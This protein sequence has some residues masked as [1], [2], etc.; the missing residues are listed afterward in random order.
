MT[1]EKVLVVELWPFPDG[2]IPSRVAIP[3]RYPPPVDE[4][5]ATAAPSSSPKSTHANDVIDDSVNNEV[6][7]CQNEDKEGNLHCLEEGHKKSTQSNNILDSYMVLHGGLVATGGLPYYNGELM[8]INQEKNEES[9]K[10]MIIST[11]PKYY[12]W[13]EAIEACDQMLTCLSFTYLHPTPLLGNVT[14]RD[15]KV[16]VEFKRE[17]SP[18]RIKGSMDNVGGTYGMVSSSNGIPRWTAVKPYPIK[19]LLAEWIR[20]NED[21]VP[22]NGNVDTVNGNASFLFTANYREC[23][24]WALD[25]HCD[26]LTAFMHEHCSFFCRV[27]EW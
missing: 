23:E 22:E 12:T 4:I 11:I 21:N 19:T 20:E 14:E 25:G 6:N 15:I 1:D 7:D 17:A 5:A 2:A 26:K 9:K 13:S 27:L 8:E 18:I 24:E 16:F 10:D 3:Q